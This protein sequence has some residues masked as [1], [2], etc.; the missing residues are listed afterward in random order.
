MAKAKFDHTRQRSPTRSSRPRRPQDDPPPDV[1]SA[2]ETARKYIEDCYATP[3][4]QAHQKAWEEL[5]NYK[6][7]ELALRQKQLEAEVLA[8]ALAKKLATKLPPGTKRSRAKF[9]EKIIQAMDDPHLQNLPRKLQA[10]KITERLGRRVNGR[11]LRRA[12]AAKRANR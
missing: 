2:L 10:A 8:D 12:A 1:A 5:E 4:A 11:Q 3:T 7:G 9:L 6:P